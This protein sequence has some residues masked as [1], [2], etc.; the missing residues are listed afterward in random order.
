[1]PSA[2][3]KKEEEKSIHEVSRKSQTSSKNTAGE[4]TTHRFRAHIHTP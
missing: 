1:M 3:E 4:V 2:G